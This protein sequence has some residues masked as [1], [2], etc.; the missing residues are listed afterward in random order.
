MHAIKL[1]AL[2]GSAPGACDPRGCL[3]SGSIIHVRVYG[4]QPLFIVGVVV[5]DFDVPGLTLQAL[6]AYYPSR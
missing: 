2:T 6:K 4:L 1:L 5:G 3:A